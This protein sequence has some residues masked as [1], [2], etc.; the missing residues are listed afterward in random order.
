MPTVVYSFSVTAFNQIGESEYSEP[1][2]VRA[3]NETD[4][5]EPQMKELNENG[6]SIELDFRET[7]E[8]IRESIDANYTYSVLMSGLSDEDIQTSNEIGRRLWKKVDFQEVL[9]G[10]T[11]PFF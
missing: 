8:K 10:V 1:L 3:L 7:D 11:E 9:S 4:V 5:K 2:Y 6:T